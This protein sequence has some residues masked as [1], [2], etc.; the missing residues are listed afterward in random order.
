MKKWLQ[1]LLAMVVVV[2]AF[3][4]A[5]TAQAADKMKDAVNEQLAGLHYDY[6]K[7]SVTL[8]NVETVKLAKPTDSGIKE[9]KIGIA[10]FSTYR[11]GIFYFHNEDFV[12]FD[13]DKQK[14][15]TYQEVAGDKNVEQ[16]RADHKGIPVKTLNIWP[17]MLLLSLV[18][19]VPAYLMYV[20]GSRQYSTTTWKN[21]NNLYGN[22]ASYR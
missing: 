20:W 14:A 21:A 4:F 11:D 18:L 22:D 17:M 8:R 10:E 16:Y 19:I 3:G 2:A 13:T 12:Y 9:V 1:A 5:G 7:D 15:I 6:K